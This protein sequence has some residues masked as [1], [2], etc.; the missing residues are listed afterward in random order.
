M[1]TLLF[2]NVES[3]YI[4]NNGKTRMLIFNYQRKRLA[5][6]TSP[7]PPLD[8][9]VTRDIIKTP[10]NTAISFIK[11]RGL[12]IVSQDGNE[13]EGIQGIWIESREENPGIYYGYIPLEVSPAIKDVEFST[14]RD[15][16]RT[17]TY[18]ELA[19]YRESRKIAEVLKQYTLFSYA[20]DP[21]NFGEDSFVVDPKHIYDVN[22]L[23]KRLISNT[24]VIYRRNK[25][26]V[27]SEAMKQKL[28]S[29]LRVS[30][31]N[32]TPGVA[33]LKT[34]TAI[35]NYYQTISDFR[36]SPNQLIFLNKNGL[37]RWRNESFRAETST[38]VSNSTNLSTA[39]PYFY[40]NPKIR[41][42]HLMIV[43]NVADG[44][45][46]NALA[47]GY[48]WIK[49]KVNIGYRPEIPNNVDEMSYTIYTE[50]G[51]NEKKKRGTTEYVSIL[52]YEDD[53][54]AALLFFN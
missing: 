15:P 46:D 18:S 2:E 37:L 38:K 14:K 17:D 36:S 4:D 32:D 49:D 39:E 8:L 9:P 27:L 23:N 48:K 34:A 22:A 47:V 6:M 16:I 7:I 24:P 31:L 52:R 54:Y 29:F 11:D 19:L 10:F 21:E 5:L 25:I 3:Q 41:R 33:T 44:A 12:T 30:L 42:E 45:F 35:E 28:M 40:R 50:I 13:D 1:A 51:E 20:N 26:I 53:T 43:Q